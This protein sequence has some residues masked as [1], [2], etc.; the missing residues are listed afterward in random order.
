MHFNQEVNDNEIFK[1]SYQRI[2]VFNLGYRFCFKTSLDVT[3]LSIFR[4]FLS[5]LPAQKI[6]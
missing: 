4:A 2:F 3:F 1:V 5:A 6:K